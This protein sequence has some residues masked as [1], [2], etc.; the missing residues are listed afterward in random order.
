MDLRFCIQ[1][2]EK[3]L[4]LRGKEQEHTG[5]LFCRRTGRQFRDKDGGFRN[6]GD[7]RGKGFNTVGGGH[8]I[9]PVHQR[10]D[11]GELLS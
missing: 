6:G 5:K 9:D 4:T 11:D 10:R 8:G 7:G 2:C 3:A 1:F